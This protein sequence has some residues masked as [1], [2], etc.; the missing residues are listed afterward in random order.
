[1]AR[2]KNIIMLGLGLL[3]S[4]ATA[5]AAGP[6]SRPAAPSAWE[7]IG[8][9]G[10]SGW[11]G[12]ATDQGVATLPAAGV[13]TFQYPAGPAGWSIAGFQV[14]N[15]STRDWRPFCGLQ[16]DVSAPAGAEVQLDVYTP[17]AALR[18]EYLPHLHAAVPVAGADGW[19]RVTVPW[20]SFGLTPSQHATLEFVQRLTLS[21]PGVRVREVRLTRG[22][23][24]ALDADVRGAS[25]DAGGTA[26]YAVTVFNCTDDPQAVTLAPEHVGWQ[27]MAVTVDPPSLVLA[28]GAAGECH[29]S[30]QVPIDGVPPGGHEAQT[31]VATAASASAELP[32]V[33]ARQLPHP[34]LVHTA[35]EWESIR[36]NV[37][38]YAWA[39]AGQAEYVRAAER[40]TVPQPLLPPDNYSATE[41]HAFAFRTADTA[42]AESTAI[43]WQL[44]RDRR[45]AEKVAEYL[46]RFSDDR[47]GY[48]AT[49]AGCSDGG[50][51]EGETFQ[52]V[53]IAYDAV[54]DAGLLGD[55]D[56]RQIE[57]TMRLFQRVFEQDLAVGNVGNW[58]VSASTACLFCALSM[59]DLAAADRYIHGPCGFT[60]YLSKGVM[61]DGW[62]WECSTSYNFWVASE[63]TQTALACRPWGIDLLDLSVPASYSPDTILTPWALDPPYGMSFQKWGPNRRSTRTVRQLW[64]ATPAA[65]DYRG[66]VFGL[67][68]GHGE[69]VG[70]NRL[71]LA[72]YA[73]RD[74]AYAALIHPA[75]KRDLL[76]A[77]PDL[78]AAGATAT[79]RPAM[80]SG[81]A[82][83]IGY[84][85]LRS[86]APGRP[87]REQ[88]QAVLKIGT[89]G[90]YH[91]HFDRCSLDH[92]SRYGRDFW[93][94][95][96][97][98]WG[99]PN[100]MYKFDVQT[101]VNHNMVVI[102]QQQQE[103]VPSTQPLFHAGP[104]M[105]AV[106]QETN[107]RWSDPPYG[108]MAYFP[109]DTFADLQRRNLQSV[110]LATDRALGE[111][112]PYSDRVLQRRAAVL[113][114]DYLLVADLVRAQRP[115]TFDC[116]FQMRGFTALDAA[117]LRPLRHDA[118]W[119]TDLHSAAQFVTNCDWSTAT[120]P[121]VGRFTMRYGGPDDPA[122]P[123]LNEPGTLHVDVHALWPP[124]QQLMLGTAAESDHTSQWVRYRVGGD[125][126][127]PLAEGETGTWILGAAD[128][129]VPVGTNARLQL[130]ATAT[131][132][133]RNSLFWTNARFVTADGT[134][135][136]VT[137][138]AGATNVAQPPTAGRD[139]YGGPVTI[140][141]AAAIHPLP[142]QPAD[143]GRPAVLSLAVPAGAVRFKATLG[144]DYPLGD[145]SQR[146]KVF[147]SRI[148]G[149]EATFLTVLEPYEDKPMVLSATATGPDV[150]RVELADGR[151]QEIRIIGL[152]GDADRIGISLR[153]TRAGTADRDERAGHE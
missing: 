109:G 84:A 150:V 21:G 52:R 153:E 148:Q 79:T 12:V 120:A 40:W 83:N 97:I 48:P 122:A 86:Q 105:Q 106:V 78:P 77:V 69:R 59:G 37:K 45:Y 5:A 110:P 131:G 31:L 32:L 142:T 126:G 24:L 149:T 42:A 81:T 19:H 8:G 108:G 44:T 30:V 100:F 43:A 135:I 98:W 1:M 20:S 85:L 101:S 56:R 39:A 50:P 146:R 4:T 67:N 15:D 94:P 141:G 66:V 147:A 82:E 47:T 28:A 3:A 138:A 117:D 130:Q 144:G 26:R 13:A 53:A 64:D 118:Q 132:S 55:A 107:A 34:Y 7:P 124:R 90:G 29:V 102:D 35:P 76:Y 127:K 60:D 62:W 74:P 11:A 2:R 65:V 68:D 119:S 61:D 114:D 111:L 113:T 70:G 33:T 93:Y 23:G 151:V 38:R 49:L 14:E 87:P 123:D 145:E 128:V 9:P 103:A 25:V 140:A 71:E 41:R 6:A 73:F 57:R 51:Q 46:R 115:H 143:G 152:G 80:P 22:S 72:Y 139:Y 58:S 91:G 104:M 63:L 121:A 129:D 133:K 36:G 116:L 137:A 54:L 17:P 95:E 134:E 88:I 136:P 125:D 18:Q 112:G 16:L 27:S 96:A 99:Y 89:Q 92:L 75:D 10:L